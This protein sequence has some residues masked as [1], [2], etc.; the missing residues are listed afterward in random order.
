MININ[1]LPDQRPNERVVLYLR[2]HWFAL[3][4]LAISFA[5]LFLVPIILGFIFWSILSA[6]LADPFFGPFTVIIG[7]IYFLSIFLFCF[8]AF[9]NY[10][11]D[12][13]IV[14]SE[15]VINIEQNGLFER[16]DSELDMIAVQDAT[17]EV[18]GMLETFFDYGDVLV[19]TAGEQEH[20]HFIHVPHPERVKQQI[21]E[22][23]IAAKE[24]LGTNAVKLGG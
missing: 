18:S 10:Y 2:R 1:H 12:T 11:L 21:M 24:Q 23:A 7:S 3:L 19:Q 22:L 20:F 9:T 17:A 4:R 8:L 13:W 14:T 6:F 16:V 5:L 15:R